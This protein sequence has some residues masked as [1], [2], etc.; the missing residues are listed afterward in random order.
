MQ[1]YP[2]THH[3]GRR[4]QGRRE[5]GEAQGVCCLTNVCESNQLSVAMQADADLGRGR[6]ARL[7][8]A[9]QNPRLSRSSPGLARSTTDLNP[10]GGKLSIPRKVGRP[11]TYPEGRSWR[12]ATYRRTS[13]D[14]LL[15]RAEACSTR[16]TKLASR[17]GAEAKIWVGRTLGAR[18][19][20]YPDLPP[21]TPDTGSR[22]RRP[23][24]LVEASP[25]IFPRL[26][27]ARAVTYL[28]YLRESTYK[29]PLARKR[30]NSS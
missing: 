26:G 23:S 3:L 29:N 5:H 16:P 1:P 7:E 15:G 25:A 10:L 17:P 2:F 9:H 8:P 12:P 19:V 14:R 4:R 13:A 21:I 20:L 28:P 22:P 11:P 30:S 18:P 24:F 6:A 27:A